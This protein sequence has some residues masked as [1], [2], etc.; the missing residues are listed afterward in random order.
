M[1]TTASEAAIVYSF[2]GEDAGG[3]GSATMT[4][5]FTSNSMLVH[6]KNTSP[7]SLVGG[8][9]V[10]APGITGFGFNF[11]NANPVDITSWDLFAA[12]TPTGSLG[13]IGGS[14]IA[15]DEN[16]APWVFNDSIAGVQI[17]FGVSASNCKGNGVQIKGALYDPDAPSSALAA[18]PN[19]FTPDPDGALLRIFFASVP[20]IID[21]AAGNCNSASC[22]PFVRM[23]NVGN[24]GSL[25]LGPGG[26]VLPPSSVP[27]PGTLALLGL[28]LVA[29]TLARVRARA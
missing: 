8:G 11:T 10:N 15:C 27:E 16:N 14:A 17:D 4:I 7:T 6:I 13:Q 29:R 9:G 20:P 23:Q 21:D 2:S 12:S 3:I 24:G 28:A 19:F 1:A 5:D 25:K 18:L 26:I 22:S